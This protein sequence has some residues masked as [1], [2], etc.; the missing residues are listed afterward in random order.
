MSP[1]S[2]SCVVLDDIT[3]MRSGIQQ[4]LTYSTCQPGFPKVHSGALP[5]AGTQRFTSI[6]DNIQDSTQHC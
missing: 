1:A 2:K 6:L 3:D 5:P 4:T